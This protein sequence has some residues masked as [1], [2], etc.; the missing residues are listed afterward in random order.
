MFRQNQ[1]GLGLLCMSIQLARPEASVPA[2]AL[3]PGGQGWQGGHAG[4]S[5]RMFCTAAMYVDACLKPD[6]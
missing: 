1:E 2:A 6:Q 4:L 5:T 3:A